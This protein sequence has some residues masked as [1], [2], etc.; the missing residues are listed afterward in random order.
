MRS[1]ELLN[2]YSNSRDEEKIQSGGY[3]E[4]VSVPSS[5]T[6]GEEGA[7]ELP[8]S[9]GSPPHGQSEKSLRIL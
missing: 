7:P 9:P 4:E 6:W 1:D 2:S 8:P 5:Q 3:V